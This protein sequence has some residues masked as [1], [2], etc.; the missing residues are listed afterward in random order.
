MSA[1][2]EQRDPRM[3]LVAQIKS[4]HVRTQIEAALPEGVSIERFERAAATAILT[5]PDL[6]NADRASLFQALVRCAH[7]GLMP[8]GRQ[9]AIVA[10]GRKASCLTMIGGYRDL[11]AEHGW[12]LRASSVRQADQ[13]DYTDEPPAIT[14]RKARENRGPVVFAY[15]VAVHR[16]GR[17]EQAVLTADEI[18]KRRAKAQTQGVW[19][20]W[21]DEQA[22]KTAGKYLASRIGLAPSDRVQRLLD[23]DTR[24][25]ADVLYN[26]PQLAGSPP[27][28]ADP[29]APS[30]GGD[31]QPSG[32][33]E[34]PP[35]VPAAGGDEWLP[36]DAV[37]ED[38]PS[39]Q[40]L[41]GAEFAAEFVPPNGKYSKPPE[42]PKTLAEIHESNPGWLKWALKTVTDPPAY[43]EALELFAEAFAPDLWQEALA[44]R[45]VAS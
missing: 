31:G 39:P 21:E 37:F 40:P 9:A 15:A 30:R 26:R 1:L 24:D 12:I 18:Q 3:D 5:R 29:P 20:E 45:E 33:D 6:L 13:F 23:V 35:F 8:D 27:P 43:R 38:E 22:A 19:N 34:S 44:A 42:G 11:L 16:D 4:P 2:P 25:A 32:A 14:H 41:A 28:P 7:T 17:R 36:E 10:Y